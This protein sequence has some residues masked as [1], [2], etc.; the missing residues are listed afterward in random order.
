ME[1]NGVSHVNFKGFMTDNAWANWNAIMKIYGEGN[2]NLL[3]VG[4]EYTCFLH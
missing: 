4:C 1:K 3:V 2:P